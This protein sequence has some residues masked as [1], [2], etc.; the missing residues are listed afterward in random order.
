MKKKVLLAVSCLLVVCL[1]SGCSVLGMSTMQ[2]LL[3]GEGNNNTTPVGAGK[4]GYIGGADLPAVGNS[5]DTVTISKKD[6]E[7]YKK[8]D[9]LFEMADIVEEYCYYDVEE[10]DMIQMAY[11]GLLAGVGDPYTF[12]YSPEDFAEMWADDEGK[13][14]GVGMQIQGNY[15]TG[16]CTITRVFDGSP[17]LEAGVLRG[18]ILYRVGEDL[19]VNAENLT[20]AVNIMRGEPGTYVNVT[21]LRNGEEVNFDLMRA[22]I[23]VNYVQDMMIDDEIGL[24]QLYEFS[25]ECEKE[26]ENRFNKL[27]EQGAKSLILDL[28]DNPGG[29][30]DAAQYIADIFCDAGDVCYLQYKDGTEEH[31]YTTKDGKKEIPMVILL[32]E[33]SASASELLSA[34]LRER[35][36]AKV[37]GVTSFGKGIVQQ[38]CYVGNEGAGMQFTIAE[39]LTPG[40]E[41]IHKIGVVPDYECPLPEGDVGMYDFGDLTDPQMAKAIEVIREMTK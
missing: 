3:S 37:V 23:T 11:T 13:Y 6:Y 36:G 5:G 14:A 9:Q 2:Y 1:L 22:N 21:F 39:Y 8:L 31:C 32:N 24:I 25:G 40:G 7:R 18:D 41:K 38:V 4:I 27:L 10:E 15:A 28:R 35:A 12:Y 29:W 30:V 16:I 33:S 17:A 34:C 26:F 19:Y 20:E